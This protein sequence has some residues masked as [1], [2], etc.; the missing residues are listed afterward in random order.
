MTKEQLGET[1][2]FLIVAVVGIFVGWFPELESVQVELITMLGIVAV[3]WI[4]G[5]PILQ[6]IAQL[7]PSLKALAAKTPN[8]T[9]D[10]LVEVIEMMLKVNQPAMVS[11]TSQITTIPGHTQSIAHA[12]A[13]GEQLVVPLPAGIDIPTAHEQIQLVL[14]KLLPPPVAPHG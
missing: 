7:L 8:K 10:R 12:A 14:G 11:E 4:F 9:D 2:Q 3:S 13:P 5:V 6:M 1:I